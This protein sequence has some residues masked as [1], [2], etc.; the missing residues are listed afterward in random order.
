MIMITVVISIPRFTV[1]STYD[2]VVLKVKFCLYQQH[3]NVRQFSPTTLIVKSHFL[4]VMLFRHATKESLT[5]IVVERL[6]PWHKLT[7]EKSS[8]YEN[9]N[10]I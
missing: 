2:Y 1:D 9:F 7:F 3:K 6:E 10:E 4:N 5:S 8:K